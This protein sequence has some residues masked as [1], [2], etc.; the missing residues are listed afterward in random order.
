MNLLSSEDRYVLMGR[1]V[2]VEIGYG[3][4]RNGWALGYEVGGAGRVLVV[5]SH[6]RADFESAWI[7]PEQVLQSSG[8][9]ILDKLRDRDYAGADQAAFERIYHEAVARAD[10]PDPVE[11]HRRPRLERTWTP[12]VGELGLALGIVAFIIF[13]FIFVVFFYRGW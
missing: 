5:W 13:L 7:W 8:D 11:V 6:T 1:E 2:T 12:T 9:H 10:E 4:Y 3:Q